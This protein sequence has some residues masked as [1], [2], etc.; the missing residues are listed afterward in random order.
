MTQ[1]AQ[2][3]APQ[4]LLAEVTHRCPLQCPYCSN[5]TE[6]TKK[7]SEISTETWAR[8]FQEA[9]E[10][11]VL[12]VS[13]SGGEPA[14]RRDLVALVDAARKADLYVN[15]ITSGI[16]ITEAKLDELHA[17]GCDHIQLS[18]Q[19]VDAAGAETI[20]NLKGSLERKLAF[21]R[22]VRDR[23]IPLTI[24]AVMHRLNLDRLP[25]TIELA[26]ELG[27]RR[28]EIANVQY[29]GWAEA[30]KQVLMPTLEQVQR[31]NAEVEAARSR[32]D[33]IMLIDYVP[34]DY[35]AEFPKAC[36]NGWGRVALVVAPDGTVLPCHNASTLTHL[37][38][39]NVQDMTLK[40]IWYQSDAFNAY[41]GDLWMPE[42]CQDC[43]RKFVDFGGCRCQA[44]AILGD[45]SQAD[46]VCSKAHPDSPM[47]A[48]LIATS[49]PINSIIYRPN[50]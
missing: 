9:A 31:T 37:R 11:G 30:N 19:D 13:V 5:P 41:R 29:H 40:D 4:V 8:I 42:I 47:R 7:E 6:L 16:G 45:A 32:Y 18:L 28:I 21:A 23:D 25:E 22:L 15:L 1:A 44:L 26:A 35:F 33:G 10:I 38:L 43:D 12:Q 27:A 14:A 48:G 24:N 36:M 17:V 50:A 20:S 3:P 2:V 39:P 49:E 46:P 34:V